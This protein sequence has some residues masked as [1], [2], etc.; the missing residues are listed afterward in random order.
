MEEPRAAQ[1]QRVTNETKID[2]SINLDAY[3]GNTFGV[4]QEISV[5]TGIGF[6]DHVREFFSVDLGR[7]IY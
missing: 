2:V 1:I 6:L 3:P 4:K 7:R 5:S